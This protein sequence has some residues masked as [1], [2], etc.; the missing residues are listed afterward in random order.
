MS[1]ETVLGRML[2]NL[3][4]LISGLAANAADLPHLQSNTQLLTQLRDELVALNDR[5]EAQK[6]ELHQVSEKLGSV[7]NRLNGEIQKARNS[8]KGVYGNRMQK[9]EE[10]GIAVKSA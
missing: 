6:A 3:N 1:A 4:V 5:Q 10:F 9:L 2:T 8:I 7:V